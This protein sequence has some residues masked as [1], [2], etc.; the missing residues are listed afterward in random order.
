MLKI[1]SYLALG[2]QEVGIQL[3]S[4]SGRWTGLVRREWTAS[5]TGG[6]TSQWLHQCRSGDPDSDPHEHLLRPLHHLAILLQEVRALQGLEH[7]ILILEVPIIEDSRA[8]LVL[9]LHHNV[10]VLFRNHRD[11]FPR[12]CILHVVQNADGIGKLL[13]CLLVEIWHSNSAITIDK[14]NKKF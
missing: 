8:H 14:C 9:V 1:S 11:T 3:G 6:R 4:W 10:V 5:V 7:K 13:L 12:D 2:T